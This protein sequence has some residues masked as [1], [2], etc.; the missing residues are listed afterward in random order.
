MV[1][2]HMSI[3]RQIE[4]KW[5]DAVS[6]TI[7]S[8]TESFSHEQFYAG[9]FW[10]CYV[11]YTMFGVPCFAMNTGSHLAATNGDAQ[12]NGTRWSPP[13]WQFDVID[14]TVETM[15]PH[16]NELSRSLAG[17][18]EADWDAAIEEHFQVLARVCRRLTRAT[19]ARAGMF[20]RI[21]LP[22]DFVV[23]VFEE[24]EGEPV[25]SRLVRAS[26]EPNVLS[27]LPFPTW[28]ES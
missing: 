11:D 8:L 7:G 13:N 10:L 14:E 24:R 18:S 22:T 1:E 3:L 19:R 9:A 26:V 28:T 20:A 23:G 2:M 15:S 4:E 6:I 17:K 5:F 21:N 25:F 16:Y 27:G 12:D